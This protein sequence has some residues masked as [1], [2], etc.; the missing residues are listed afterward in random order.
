MNIAQLKAAVDQIHDGC[1]RAG[2]QPVKIMV[3]D[4]IGNL[5]P[6]ESLYVGTIDGLENS[7]QVVIIENADLPLNRMQKVKAAEEAAKKRGAK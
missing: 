3:R 2:A 6:L 1:K 4:P 7:E 5:H